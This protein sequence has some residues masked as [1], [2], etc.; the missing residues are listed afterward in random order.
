[1]AK[2][3]T[4]TSGGFDFDEFAESE[5][6]NNAKKLAEQQANYRVYSTGSL[7][8][9]CAIGEKDPLNGNGGIPER[10]IVEVFGKNQSLK[11]RAF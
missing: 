8:L 4:A 7:M 2:K 10:T 9:D 6:I 5:G 1:M 3:K 11:S